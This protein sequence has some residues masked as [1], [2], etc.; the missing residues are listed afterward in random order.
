MHRHLARRT[1][2]AA[3][4]AVG[5]GTAFAAAASAHGGPS[6]QPADHV[7]E[8][9]NASSGKARSLLCTNTRRWSAR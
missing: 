4:L 8:T 7:Y 3:A 1:L 6:H 5:L 2:S 9:T